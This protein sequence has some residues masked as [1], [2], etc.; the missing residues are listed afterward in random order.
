MERCNH[1]IMP[2]PQL[3]EVLFAFKSKVSA[4][5]RD[6]LGIHEIDHIAFT[7]IN[8]HNQLLTL[9]S[10]PAMEFNLFSGSL[11]RYDKTYASQWY[12]SCVQ[13]YWQNL[14][15]QARYD[16]LYYLKQIK[17]HYPVGLSLA[18]KMDEEYIIFSLAS[19]KFC[20]HTREL[21]AHQHD[22]FYK[23]GQYCSNQLNPLLNNCDNFSSNPSFMQ[24]E[25]ETS[26]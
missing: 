23:I 26:K 11:W 6:V 13:D 15:T 19:R 20:D 25:Y 8:K 14:Y 22:D 2:H 7:R 1:E 5:F 21:F 12:Q 4:V 17:H 18:A 3:L 24:V 9:S 16:E 10:T